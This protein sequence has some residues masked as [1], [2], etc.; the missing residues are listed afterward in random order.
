MS[1]L[2]LALSEPLV[3]AAFGGLCIYALVNTGAFVAFAIDKRR[4]TRT[5][6]RISERS[7]HV[8]TIFGALG[9]LGAIFGLRHKTR[10]ARFLAVT[11]VAVIAHGALLVGAWCVVAHF[12]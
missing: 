4:A 2:S 11:V 5:Q 8:L 10:K 3:A 7:L 12:M 6:R 9:A 1:R